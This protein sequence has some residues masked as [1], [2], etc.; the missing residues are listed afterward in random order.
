MMIRSLSGAVY[1]ALIIGCILA[2]NLWFAILT[3]ILIVL[4]MYELQSLL[5]K[6]SPMASGI[7]F[8]DIAMALCL[9]AGLSLINLYS[10]LAGTYFICF[11]VLYISL[12]IILAV[13][14]K[15]ENPAKSML[16]SLLSMCY[17]AWP[18]LLLYIAYSNYTDGKALVLITFIL[19]WVNDTGAYLSGMSM[20]RHKMCERLSP[21]KTWEGF[22][23]GFILCIVAGIVSAMI[24][25]HAGLEKMIIWGVYAALVSLFGTFGDLFESLI[26]RNLNVKD[27]GNLI[28]GHGGILDRIDSILAVAPLAA[29]MSS[30][31]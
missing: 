5:T 21:K 30:I 23:G 31:L 18:L 8:F 9:L 26:K 7:R 28:P 2:G 1:V 22:W 10:S 6:R 12:R 29:L 27:S 13:A 25:G 15:G 20:G 16:Y 24:I 4:S 11:G 19:I 14:D 3:G 17:L